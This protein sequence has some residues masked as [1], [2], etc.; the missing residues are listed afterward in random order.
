MG[1][2]KPKYVIVVYEAADID[3]DAL[4]IVSPEPPPL[5]TRDALDRLPD[6][7]WSVWS[8]RRRLARAKQRKTAGAAN[9]DRSR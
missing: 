3:L 5:Q 8:E 4:G 7:E 1:N 6:E 9:A 2:R